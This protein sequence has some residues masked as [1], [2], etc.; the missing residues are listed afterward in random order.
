MAD[1]RSEL[2]SK[3]LELEARANDPNRLF[4]NRGGQL[5]REERERNSLSKVLSSSFYVYFVLECPC[6]IIEFHSNFIINHLFQAIPKIEKELKERLLEYEQENST[7]FYLN[8][9]NLLDLIEQETEVRQGMKELQKQQKVNCDLSIHL[10]LK[11][12]FSHKSIFQ[13]SY[14]CIMCCRGSPGVIS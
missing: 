7:P 2:W 5:L 3:V 1:Q 11:M 8:G 13:S 9:Q 4:N 12:I 10:P 14:I 6:I